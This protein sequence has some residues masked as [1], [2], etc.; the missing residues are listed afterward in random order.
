[1][2]VADAAADDVGRR[3]CRQAGAHRGHTNICM[4]NSLWLVWS[5]PKCTPEMMRSTQELVCSC[6]CMPYIVMALHAHTCV[7][8][9]QSCMQ[10]T[11]WLR[12][13]FELHATQVTYSHL[14]PCAYTTRIHSRHAC[15]HSQQACMHGVSSLH[16]CHQK[17]HLCY[18]NWHMNV[19]ACMQAS[20]QVKSRAMAETGQRISIV[21]CHPLSFKCAHLLCCC[22][23]GCSD[24]SPC[25]PT[26]Q[27]LTRGG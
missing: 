16:H 25:R 7:S 19:A 1:M 4:L 17:P 22:R 15:K 27:Q 24:E 26:Q 23:V 13:T 21:V 18:M 14:R 3:S 9:P 2:I 11:H 20:K 8:S 5:R 6:T 12:D 10:H